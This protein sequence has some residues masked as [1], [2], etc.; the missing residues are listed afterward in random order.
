MGKVKDEFDIPTAK[1]SI[2]LYLEEW[3]AG[4]ITEA[5]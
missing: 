2:V 1:S 5:M 4:S 3:L